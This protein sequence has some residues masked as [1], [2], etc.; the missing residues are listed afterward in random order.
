MKKLSLI[1]VGLL[2]SLLT[3]SAFAV[4]L[5]TFDGPQARSSVK[6]GDSTVASPRAFAAKFNPAAMEQE[7]IDINLP[8][9][10]IAAKRMS[11]VGDASEQITPYS[12]ENQKGSVTVNSKNDK[13]ESLTIFD[14]Q[15]NEVFKGAIQ[16]D[17]SIAFTQVD[18]DAFICSNYDK[19]SS[20]SGP[21]A[22]DTSYYQSLNSLTQTQ[23]STLQSRP[24]ASKI[25]Y[26]DYFAGSVTGTAWNVD[27]SI[28]EIVYD[29]YSYDSDASTF[30][31]IDLQSMYAG[32]AETAEDYAPFDV[33]VTTD[34]SVYQAASNRN[35]S[36]IIATSTNWRGSGGVAYVD[37]FGLRNDDYYNIGWTFNSSFGSLGMTNAHES[38]H[39]MGLNHDGTS[40]L[41]YYG[42]NGNAGPIMGGPFGKDFVHWN[43]GS[44]VGA[45]QTQNDLA[46]IQ[47]KLGVIAD[48]HGNDNNSAT[49]ISAQEIVGFISPAG[50]AADTDVFSFTLASST[51][52][53]LTVRSLFEQATA[54]GDNTAGGLNLSAK[55]E[56]R[57]ASNT[58]IQQKLPSSIAANNN[59]SFSQSLA[60][61][62]YYL[63]IEP[64]AYTPSDFNEYGNGGYYQIL[65][66]LNAITA[67]DLVVEAASVNNSNVDAGAAFV[68]SATPKNQ[69]NALSAA[70]TLTYYR[71]SDATITTSDVSVGV[72][73]VASFTAGASGVESIN[74]IAPASPGDYYYGACSAS[75]SGELNTGNNCS[76][77]ALLTVAA[78]VDLIVESPAVDSS[79]LTPSQTFLLSVSVKNEGNSNSSA[80]TLTYYRSTNSRI[81][82]QDVSVGSDD[83]GVL[84]ANVS[85]PE[86]ISLSAPAATGNYYYGACVTSFSGETGNNNCSIAV[87]VSVTPP[88]TVDLVVESP[89]VSDN[90]LNPSQTFQL[91][92]SVRNQG[93]SNALATTLVYY[94]STDTLISTSDDNVGSDEVGAM[95]GGVSSP[96]SI[97]LSAPTTPG[98]YY[99]GACVTTFSGEISTNNCS[100]AVAVSVAAPG[101][102]D[103]VIVASSVSDETLGAGQDFAFSAVIKN[104]GSVT[105]RSTSL[106]YYRSV[107][108]NIDSS[109]VNVG[110]DGVSPIEAGRTEVESIS[111]TAPSV[112]GNY[113]IGACVTAPSNETTSDNNCSTGLLVTVADSTPIIADSYEPNND[114]ASAKGI[115]AGQVQ[116]HTMHV[117]GDKDW[118]EFTL[119][120]ASN[121]LVI[122]TDGSN[123][124][125]TRLWL[126][127]SNL[128][129]VAFDDDGGNGN[130][131]KIS[132][133]SLLAAGTYFIQVDEYDNDDLIG[134]YTVT[135]NFDSV[136]EEDQSFCLPIKATKGNL[137]IICL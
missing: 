17:G 16:A 73:D 20:L 35:K 72:D 86:S 28:Q 67:P 1:C 31:L 40:S 93:N 59:F 38:G 47:G 106:T 114:S 13:I 43:N 65:N 53:S 102:V 98:S 74:L 94:R 83:I 63:T 127:D 49:A 85:A 131:S 88:A 3:P 4:D 77:G 44:Y 23:V 5:F 87:L 111:L 92:A 116:S 54:G 24:G 95:G 69:G 105:S 79:S 26:I 10:V 125:D 91:S 60:A 110:N 81:T 45:N 56:L 135:L 107:D 124:D 50:L 15:A 122:E 123:S 133:S 68:L 126:Y 25:L 34:L 46:I 61:G 37:V 101:T 22:A 19:V 30:S 121:N 14:A 21:Q 109:D 120:S 70:T 36:K 119:S 137:A 18:I 55:I 78:T 7:S 39:Q 76:A 11:S 66:D 136:S 89:A 108:A 9:K 64:Q 57:D 58:L 104:E 51:S 84:G 129:Q 132:L 27:N 8:H 71:S 134:D 97:N 99:Y 100:A 112:P 52:V 62:T 12:F 48:D 118:L 113:Y 42:G 41:E 32:W 96:E 82:T 80:T 130:Y 128:S 6:Q 90:T 117:A 2:A 29:N 75:V 33:N 115:L 103:L